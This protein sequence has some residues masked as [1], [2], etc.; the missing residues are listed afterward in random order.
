MRTLDRDCGSILLAR[1]GTRSAC[2]CCL[3]IVAS[4]LAGGCTPVKTAKSYWLRVTGQQPTQ[5]ESADVADDQPE[6]DGQVMEDANITEP[7]VNES[8]AGEQQATSSVEEN[9][10]SKGDMAWAFTAV[11]NSTPLSTEELEDGLVLSVLRENDDPEAP[12]CEMDS[13]I[14]VRYRGELEDGTVF[15]A[16]DSNDDPVG[17]WPLEQLI[18]GWRLGLVGMKVGEVR[19]LVIPPDLAY[20]EEVLTDP[21]TGAEI[22]PA[23]ATLIFTIELVDIQNQ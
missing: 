15:D 5:T 20:G 18:D 12:T 21:E 22:I 11:E 7:S 14:V 23:F 16:T 3:T 8:M 19:R 13:R 17:P 6:V 4:L 9:G 10:S 2:W 1:A